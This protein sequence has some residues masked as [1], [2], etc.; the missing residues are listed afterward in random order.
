MC[1]AVNYNSH[2]HYFGRTLDWGFS[3]GEKVAVTP[4]K[5]NLK[6][7]KL[8]EISTHYAMIGMAVVAENYPLY[9]DATNEKGLSMAGLNF[10]QNAEYL[11]FKENFYNVTVSEIIPWVLSQCENVEGARALI[12]K[13]NVLNLQPD[14]NFPLP[15]MHWIISDKVKSITVEPLADGLKIYDNPVGVLANNPPFPYHMYNIC[16]YMNLTSHDPE[17]SFSNKLDLNIFCKGMGSIGLPGDPSSPSRF[18]RAAYCALNSVEYEDEGENVAQFFHILGAVEQVEG[19]AY[20]D[21][22]SFEKTLYTSCCNTDKGIYYYRTNLNNQINAV[23]M[24]KENIDGEELLTF[25]LNK[26]Q[27]INYQN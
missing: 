11:P 24:Y 21:E 1:T 23:N 22:H 13:T 3:Y 20:A 18:I 17:N 6:F 2:D 4:R 16:N 7:E 5:F 8:P 27:N 10:P 26:K 9:F 25:Q 15:P 14:P 12:E 19:C